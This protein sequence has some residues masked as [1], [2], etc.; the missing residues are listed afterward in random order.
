MQSSEV[1][2][3]KSAGNGA[4]INEPRIDEELFSPVEFGKIIEPQPVL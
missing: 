3:I 1:G 2:I 4:H